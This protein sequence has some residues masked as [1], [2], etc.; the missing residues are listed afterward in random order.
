MFDATTGNTD[1]PASTDY[2]FSPRQ[3]DTL[4]PP[5][6]LLRHLPSI[7]SNFGLLRLQTR[8]ELSQSHLTV[9]QQA[10]IRAIQSLPMFSMKQYTLHFHIGHN[11][12]LEKGC[13]I[14]S[15]CKSMRMVCFLHSCIHF[16]SGECLHEV[17]TSRNVGRMVQCEVEAPIVSTATMHKPTARPP[18]L[19]SH[20]KR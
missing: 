2:A 20:L 7:C 14:Q 9:A 11:N 19:P 1:G 3:S 15:H 4:P 18:F 6:H 10:C 17:V 5:F 16:T 8:L 13:P 12:Y